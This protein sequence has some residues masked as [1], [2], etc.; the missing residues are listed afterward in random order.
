MS[1]V[2]NNLGREEKVVLRIKK[3]WLS[4]LAPIIWAV[5]FVVLGILAMVFIS[6]AVQEGGNQ[7]DADKIGLILML[8]CFAIAILIVVIAVLKY[9]SWELALT[10]KRLI[11]KKGLLRVDALDVPLDKIDHVDVNASFWQ[12]L[13]HYYR[14]SVSSVGGSTSSGK[15][16]KGDAGFVGVVNANE[17]KNA[18][19]EAV[20]L[21]AAEARRAQA[22][23]IARA[24]GRNV[25]E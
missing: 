11:G 21:R 15:R 17:F 23:E 8:V 3:S 14:I 16:G 6:G 20:E 4:M 13:L 12:R 19:T 24:M 22:L 1:Y 2:D 7:E 5:L 10:N 25:D 9:L 18:V